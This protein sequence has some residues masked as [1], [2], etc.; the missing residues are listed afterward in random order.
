MGLGFR[1]CGLGFGFVWKFF[2]ASDSVP[3]PGGRVS[4]IQISS[5]LKPANYKYDRGL[6]CL[7]LG[8]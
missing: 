7:G 6:G 2:G 5:T 1:V 4:S 8:L 3:A